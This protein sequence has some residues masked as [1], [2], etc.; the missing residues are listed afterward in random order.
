M[1]TAGKRE[2]EAEQQPDCVQS[3]PPLGPTESGAGEIAGFCLA[4]LVSLMLGVSGGSAPPWAL[5]TP[6]VG[7]WGV[8]TSP[9][10]H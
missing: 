3:E 7:N 9:N 1:L 2:E 6:G 5:M 4:Q 8:L 10:S